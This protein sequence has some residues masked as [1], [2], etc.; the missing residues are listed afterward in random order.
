M[1][2]MVICFLLDFVLWCH[3]SACF[4]SAPCVVV[5]VQF[6]SVHCL[7]LSLRITL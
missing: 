4:C 1:A 7:L 2:R 6:S 5:E 3:C